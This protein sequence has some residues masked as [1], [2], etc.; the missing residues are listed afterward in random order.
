MKKNYFDLTISYDLTKLSINRKDNFNCQLVDERGTV[1]DGFRLSQSKTGK[2]ITVCDID[3]QKSERDNKYQARLIFRKTDDGFNTRNVR[4]GSDCIRIPFKTGQDGYREFWRM[5]AFL[6]MWRETIDLGEFEDY[7]SVTEKSLADILP[8]IANVENRKVVL[9]NLEKLSSVDLENIDNLVNTT[10]IKKIIEIWQENKNNDDEKFWQN[11]F[12]ENNFILSQVFACPFIFIDEQF[13][14]GGKRGTNKGGVETDFIYQNK[15]TQN[16]A[17]IEIKTPITDLTNKSL[18]LGKSDNDNNAIYCINS[19]LTGGI[20]ELLNQRN[21]F[22]QKKDSLEEIERKHENFKCIFI[23][24]MIS[25]LTSGQLKS[26]ELYR[27]SLRD[28]EIIT[29]DELL[30]RIKGILNIFNE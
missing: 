24:G 18:Y 5:I 15:L 11:L 10:K 17:F 28:V 3:F 21:R 23:G 1:Y 16:T 2:V 30:E 12:K 20:N 8:K 6:Y 13:F 22:I 29:Y 9:E 25:S 26:F 27:N 7:F 19:E 14:C 4:K